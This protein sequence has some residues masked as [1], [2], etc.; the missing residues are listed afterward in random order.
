MHFTFI[1][2]HNKYMGNIQSSAYQCV[3]SLTVVG[4]S[5]AKTRVS[6]TSIAKMSSITSMSNTSKPGIDGSCI[7]SVSGDNS[8]I[9]GMSGSVGV[10]EGESSTDLTDGISISISFS[11]SLTLAVMS[12]ISVSK[13]S[14]TGVSMSSKTGVSESSITN[15]SNMSNMSNTG[16]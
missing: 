12:S 5:I 3:P 8:S 6:Q 14:K 10:M 7:R 2:S 1:G 4:T 16:I 11:L 9:V 15:M 13:S